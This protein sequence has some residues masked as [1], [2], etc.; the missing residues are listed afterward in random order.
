[1]VFTQLTE[2]EYAAFESQHEYGSFLQSISSYRWKK[3]DGIECY[4][5]GVKEDNQILAAT[6]VYATPV[7]KVFKYFYAPRGFLIDYKNKEVLQFFIEKLSDF[8]KARKGLYLK[9][10][11][12]VLYQEHDMDANVVEGGFNNQ[13]VIDTLQSLGCHHSGFTVGISNGSQA[14]WMISLYLQNKDEKT[15]LK[16]MRN[17]TRRSIKKTEKSGIKVRL[18]SLDEIDTFVNMLKK[19]GERRNFDVREK[20][21]Y[22]KQAKA[23]GSDCKILLA[24]MDV[25]E[26]LE[27]LEKELK[28]TNKKQKGVLERLEKDP[29]NEKNIKKKELNEETILN[30]SKKLDEIRNLQKNHGDII[31]MA[32]SLF[33]MQPQECVYLC[34]A[35]DEE[36]MKYDAPYA[37]QWHMIQESMKLGINRFNFYGQTGDFT[38]NAADYGVYEFKKGFGGIV[39]ELV[40]EFTLPIKK[41][42]F[43]LYNAIKHV[44]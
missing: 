42:W 19:T 17:L 1:M 22:L 9:F 29:E 38:K 21:F 44:I 25:K 32:T 43:A 15:I 26:Y 7:A 13:Y 10:D 12:Y 24:Y 23:F 2:Q 16:E 28:D 20:E 31:E 41:N 34:G 27:S 35:A 4:L 5:V 30:V 39:E 37:I 14:R 3:S 11:P 18:L 40:G 33:I 6:Y 36:F 8:L